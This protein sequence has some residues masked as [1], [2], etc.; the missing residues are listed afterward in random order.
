MLDKI[1]RS[2]SHSIILCE[3]SKIVSILV[4]TAMRLAILRRYSYII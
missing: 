4:I 3:E 1:I 2:H